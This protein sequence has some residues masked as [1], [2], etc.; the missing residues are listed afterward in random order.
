MQR[1]DQ[2]YEKAIYISFF[3]V[4]YLQKSAKMELIATFLHFISKKFANVT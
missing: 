1:V 4:M 2:Q 3:D